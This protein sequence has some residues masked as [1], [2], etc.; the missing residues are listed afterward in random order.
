MPYWS[1]QS[2]FLPFNDTAYYYGKSIKNIYLSGGMNTTAIDNFREG[3]AIRTV[4]EL[5]KSSQLKVSFLDGQ[6]E[7]SLEPNGKLVHQ[8]TFQTYGQAVDFVQYTGISTFNDAHK[9]IDGTFQGANGISYST[10]VEYLIDSGH[11][12]DGTLDGSQVYPIFMNGGPQFT[13]E[14]IIEPF[15][16]PFRLATNESPQEVSRG[17]FAFLEGGNYGDERRFG[18]NIVEQRVD[19]N[20]PVSVRPY[21][22]LGGSYLVVSNSSGL[23]KIIH[24]RPSA[25]PDQTVITRPQ[26]WLDEDPGA[27]LPRIT[28]T[29][30][31]LSASVGGIPYY[32]VNYRMEDSELGTRDQKSATAGFSYYGGANEYYGTDSIAFGG[33]Y[34]G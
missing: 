22:E 21:L 20:Q 24:T 13:E 28:N 18:T 6:Q 25:I 30:D 4:G 17:I 34:K 27:Y 15:S 10:V 14:A 8:S 19:R 23:L 5:Y 1:T 3:T 16:I 2:T 9:G 31:L 7:L 33:L 12:V 26:P 11:V 29:L 32:K